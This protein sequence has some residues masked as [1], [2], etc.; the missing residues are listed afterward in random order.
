MIK[1][2]WEKIKSETNGDSISILTIVHL[3]TYKIVPASRKDKTYKYFGKSSKA[4][5]C[6]TKKL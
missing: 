1:Y 4:T 2:N 5:T 3:L 6:R